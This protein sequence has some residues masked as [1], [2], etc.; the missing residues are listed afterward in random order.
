MSALTWITEKELGRGIKKQRRPISL[1]EKRKH[2]I[3]AVRK[4]DMLAATKE[5]MSGSEKKKVNRN[6]YDINPQKNT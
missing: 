6:T 2:F 3:A 4:W 1:E 5:K